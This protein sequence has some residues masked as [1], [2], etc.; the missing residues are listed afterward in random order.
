MLELEKVLYARGSH[1]AGLLPHEASGIQGFS[2]RM[3]APEN[4][5]R[6]YPEVVAAVPRGGCAIHHCLTAHR[7]GPNVTDRRRRA[8]VADYRTVAASESEPLRQKVDRERNEL[9][10]RLGGG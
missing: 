8:I 10:K 2:Q 7:S 9:L 3:V 4:Q 5:L 6:P 1:V